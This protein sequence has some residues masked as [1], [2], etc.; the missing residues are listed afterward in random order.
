M[1]IRLKLDLVVVVVVVVAV[2]VQRSLGRREGTGAAGRLL[3]R[4]SVGRAA[5]QAHREPSAERSAAERRPPRGFS[6]NVK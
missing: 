3:N 5:K 6:S 2:A 1:R 4:P